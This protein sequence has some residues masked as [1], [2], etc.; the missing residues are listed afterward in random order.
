MK[1]L[2][3]SKCGNI[4]ERL[5]QSYCNSC[6]AEYARLNRPKHSEL[7]DLARI[8][9]NARAYLHE[10]VRRGKVQ[11]LPCLICGTT[12]NLEAHHHDYSKPLAVEWYCR[13]HH[14]EIHSQK[15]QLPLLKASA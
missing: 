7:N 4:K 14:L 1:G 5:G 13:T 12:E 10:Y 6:H 3:C 9:A 11:K 2:Y 8:K 15:L